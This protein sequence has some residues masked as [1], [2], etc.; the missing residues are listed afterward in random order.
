MPSARPVLIFLSCALLPARAFHRWELDHACNDL[1]AIAPED[2]EQL[3]DIV[4][5]GDCVGDCERAFAMA[6]DSGSYFHVRALAAHHGERVRDAMELTLR[7]LRLDLAQ[8]HRSVLHPELTPRTCYRRSVRREATAREV[9]LRYDADRSG[10]IEAGE[11]EAMLTEMGFPPA[12]VAE[13]WT[14]AD[15]NHD[16]TLARRRFVQKHFFFSIER[17]AFCTVT[18]PDHS[19]AR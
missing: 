2:K 1:H 11:M 15:A 7:D 4:L 8:G 13:T 16:G 14:K 10:T 17:A 5:Y 3:K 9:F 12:F 6:H 18:G 19:Y